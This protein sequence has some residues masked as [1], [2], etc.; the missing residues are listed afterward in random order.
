[1]DAAAPVPLKAIVSGEVDAVLVTVAI[2]VRLPA[3]AG[4]NSMPKEVDC[5]AARVTG[6][7]TLEWENP[8][9]ETEMLDT[10]TLA[11]PLFVSVTV[12]VELVPVVKLPKLKDVGD[13]E[14]CRTDA[15]LVPESGTTSGEVGE[16]LVSDRFV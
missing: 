9:P 11:F 14:S 15:T 4:E 12:C 2:P 3:E 6:S 13:A 1:M 5:P 8:V 7:A 16:L 10:D